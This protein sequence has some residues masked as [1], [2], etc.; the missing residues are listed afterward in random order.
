MKH[1]SAV[2]FAVGYEKSMG[3][4]VIPKSPK[5]RKKVEKLDWAPLNCWEGG[6]EGEEIAYCFQ[7][8]RQL[9]IKYG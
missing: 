7:D 3:F 4:L 8:T 1:F 5:V 2:K 9:R 6:N